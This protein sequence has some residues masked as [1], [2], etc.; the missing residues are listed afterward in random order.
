[1]NIEA[2][3]TAADRSE[4]FRKL[5]RMRLEPSPVS[6]ESKLWNSQVFQLN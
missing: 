3:R 5:A 4:L 2:G 1:M 6:E